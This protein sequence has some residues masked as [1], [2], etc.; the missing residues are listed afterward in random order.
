MGTVEFDGHAQG[1]RKPQNFIVYPMP[2]SGEEI[3]I[4]SDKRF[5]RLDLGT[6]K[7]LLSANKDGANSVWLMVCRIRRTTIEIQLSDEDRQTLRA[8]VKATGGLLVGDSFIKSDN[9]GA[10][11][12]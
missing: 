10:I 6:G 8:A 4:Q 1:M 11:A 2:N 9:T 5:G 7:G 3:T 12:L